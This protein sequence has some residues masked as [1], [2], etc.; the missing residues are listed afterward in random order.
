MELARLY[1]DSYK[2][3]PELLMNWKSSGVS[4]VYERLDNKKLCGFKQAVDNII[5]CHPLPIN[6]YSISSF[7]EKQILDYCA[8]NLPEAY[9]SAVQ[10][11][12]E[13]MPQLW[14]IL[15]SINP[16]FSRTYL[17]GDEEKTLWFEYVHQET[18]TAYTLSEISDG[19]R[20]LFTLYFLVVMYFGEDYSLFLDEPDNYISLQEVGQFIQYVQDRASDKKQCVFIS[21]HPSIIDYFAPA[22]GIWLERRSYGATTLSAPPKNDC[23]LTYSEIIAQGG[24]NE[25]E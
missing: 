17:K 4:S 18:K 11:N 24:V 12:P 5:I 14:E 23:G 7:F 25:A 9:L 1:N 8:D 13:K 3:G 22:N 20:M 19:E 10:S 2:E 16:S 15:K 6:H 21:H